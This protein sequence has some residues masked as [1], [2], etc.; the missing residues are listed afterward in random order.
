MPKQGEIVLIPVPFTH[1]T[2]NK[3]RPVIIVSN[4]DYNQF[5]VESERQ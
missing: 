1:L 2:S 5:V 3:R 4:D